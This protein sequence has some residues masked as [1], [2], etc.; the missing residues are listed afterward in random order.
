ME[1]RYYFLSKWTWYEWLG[2]LAPLALVAWFVRLGHR[3]GRLALAYMCERLFYFGLFQFSAATASEDHGISTD[4]LDA[5]VLPAFFRLRRRTDGRVCS[6]PP[7]RALLA[8][9][10]VLAFTKARIKLNPREWQ[11]RQAG[12]VFVLA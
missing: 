12:A 4:A 11:W 2:I 6:R 1:R 8:L 3:H 9:F 10:F 5:P 7:P